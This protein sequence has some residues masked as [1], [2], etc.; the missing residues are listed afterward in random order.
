VRFEHDLPPKNKTQPF[1]DL[2]LHVTN[3]LAMLTLQK[4]K[5]RKYKNARA[6][7]TKTLSEKSDFANHNLCQKK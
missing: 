3:F 5:L 4:P 6:E 2:I 1:T 7:L